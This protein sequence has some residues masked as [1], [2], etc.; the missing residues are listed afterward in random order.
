MG[1]WFRKNFGNPKSK[2]CLQ[3]TILGLGARFLQ[4]SHPALWV[5]LCEDHRRGG[6]RRA[7]PRYRLAWAGVTR[8]WP[9][10]P[11]SHHLLRA[12]SRA[13]NPDCRRAGSGYDTWRENG[14]RWLSISPGLGTE[15]KAPLLR[16]T[17]SLCWHAE[18]AHFT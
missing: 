1:L 2:A 5:R 18:V 16:V 10:T 13:L 12:H 8:S 15:S 17:C 9:P 3:P 7:A 14:Q 11:A 4:N 6:G